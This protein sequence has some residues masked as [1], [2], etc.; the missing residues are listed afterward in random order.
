MAFD[1]VQE[2]KELVAQVPELPIQDFG[3][4]YIYPV[5]VVLIIIE[6]LKAKELFDL[7]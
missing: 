6:Y 7:K 3:L 2:W 5:F 1:L 4:T